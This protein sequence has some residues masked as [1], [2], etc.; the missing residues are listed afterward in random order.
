[1]IVSGVSGSYEMLLA[2]HFDAKRV[3][4]T[5]R[6]ICAVSE[7]V[8]HPYTRSSDCSETER[9]LRRGKRRLSVVA[10]QF[11]QLGYRT[12]TQEF[13]FRGLVATNALF[14]Q[15]PLSE[16][17][18]LLAGHHDYS[19]GL[20]A[21]DNGTALAVMLELGRCLE[22]NASGIIFA[23]FDLEEVSLLGS[24]HFVATSSEKQ[25]QGL[26]GVVAL[27]C[28]GSG[29][30]VVICRAVAG[31]E[32]NPALVSELERAAKKLGIQFL[33]RVLTGSTPIMFHL[34]SEA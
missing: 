29:K 2:K 10:T 21:E 23:S 30:D 11:E 14:V 9:Y 32:S 18:L 17:I 31:A 22:Q 16:G 5:I 34:R 12:I 4:Q 1:M 19:A 6:E 20:G 26:S 28:L 15:G 24:R 3:L 25:L 8:Y 33:S 7:F 13:G 27:E